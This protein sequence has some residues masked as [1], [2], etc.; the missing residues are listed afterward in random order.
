MLADL[1]KVI[2]ALKRRDADQ[3]EQLMV[4]HVE[5]FV[6]AVGRFFYLRGVDWTFSSLRNS[7]NNHVKGEQKWRKDRS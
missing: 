5:N 6:R 2:Q 1:P 3:M 7:P 4:E